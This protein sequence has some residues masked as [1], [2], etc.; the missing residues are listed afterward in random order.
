MN[1][2]GGS[3]T[4]AHQVMD[5]TNVDTVYFVVSYY[6]WDAQSIIVKAKKQAA[7]SWVINDKNF[8]FKYTR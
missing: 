4:T 6:W 1:K 7:K 5:L 2:N 8:I 3:T